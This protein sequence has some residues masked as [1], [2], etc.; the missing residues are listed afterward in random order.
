MRQ[1]ARVALT[2]S[3]LLGWL[4]SAI[5][6]GAPGATGAAMV[7][8]ESWW[9]WNSPWARNAVHFLQERI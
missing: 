4:T 3:A 7:D 1:A 2:A 6:I 9:G 8:S 5:V